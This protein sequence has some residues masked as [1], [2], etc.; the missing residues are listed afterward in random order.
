MVSRI[1]VFYYFYYFLV[2]FTENFQILNF[3]I[4]ITVTK[5]TQVQYKASRIQVFPI[6]T[7]H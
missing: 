3:Q 1:V 6:L 2:F 4:I 5:L 7:E